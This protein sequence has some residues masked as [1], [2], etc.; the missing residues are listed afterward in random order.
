MPKGETPKGEMI[1]KERFEAFLKWEDRQTK[2]RMD[3]QVVLENLIAWNEEYPEDERD[4]V[5]LL[6]T[7]DNLVKLTEVI[8]EVVRRETLQWVAENLVDTLEQD[9]EEEEPQPGFDWGMVMSVM[10]EDHNWTE[11]IDEQEQ[12]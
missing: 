4:V 9:L 8:A 7:A 3:V 11:V 1:N 12:G 2:M 5:D 6:G 10:G